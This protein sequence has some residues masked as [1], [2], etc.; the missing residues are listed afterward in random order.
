[1][2]DSACRSVAFIRNSQKDIFFPGRGETPE[3]AISKFCFICTVK[4]ECNDYADRNNAK[5]GIWGGVRRIRKDG[6]EAE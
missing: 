2:K 1:M 5:T 4:T 6:S 3:M